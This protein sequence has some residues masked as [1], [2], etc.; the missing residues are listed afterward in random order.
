MRCDAKPTLAQ[1]ALDLLIDLS[2]AGGIAPVPVN[3]L[4]A[5]LGND[6]IEELCRHSGAHDQQNPFLSNRLTHRF[7]TLVQ[8]PARR[9]ARRAHALVGLVDV[10]GNDPAAIRSGGQQGRV[11]AEAQVIA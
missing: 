2:L 10:E 5:V 8:P 6:L 4:R 11:V 7:Q 1:V 9:A 3:G